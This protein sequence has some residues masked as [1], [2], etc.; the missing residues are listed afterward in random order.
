MSDR[1]AS[2]VYNAKYTDRQYRETLDGCEVARWRALR[3]FIRQ[4]API[5]DRSSSLA[6]LDYGA[7]SGLFVDLWKATFP[8]A[9][10]YATDVSSVALERLIQRHPELLGRVGLVE[11]DRAPFDDA[12]FDVVTSVEVME[13]VLDLDAYLRDVYRL[14]KPGGVFIWTTPCANRFSI[15]HLYCLSLGQIEATSE[16]YRRW[17]WEEPTHVRRL[18]SEEARAHLAQAGFRDVA[19]RFRAHFFSAV[20]AYLLRGPLKPAAERLMLLDYALFR[21][22]PNGASM[23]GAAVRS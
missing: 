5:G 20:C 21:R 12:Q 22:L 11:G 16:G 18:R 4:I 7:G 19:F 9:A 14:L 8:G 2:G 17:T 13:H 6:L 1:I 15:E 3:H 23:I 10:L